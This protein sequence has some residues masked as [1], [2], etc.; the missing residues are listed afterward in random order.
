M[1]RWIALLLTVALCLSLVACVGSPA[2]P[3]QPGA[4]TEPV[5][6]PSE[7]TTE[8]VTQ[9]TELREPVAELQSV[10]PAILGGLIASSGSRVAVSWMDPDLQY[11]TVQLVDVNKDEVCGEIRLDGLWTLKDQTFAD[12]RVALYQRETNTWKFLSGSMEEL[13]TWTAENVDG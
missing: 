8:P 6:Q 12:G 3:T 7:P 1:K 11:T 2:Q 10:H 4:S 13:G 5:T 9:P